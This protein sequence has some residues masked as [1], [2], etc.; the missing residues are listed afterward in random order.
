MREGTDFRW[1][2]FDGKLKQRRSWRG[3]FIL[4]LLFLA[5]VFP[6]GLLAENLG[7]GL[8][9]YSPFDGTSAP[10]FA[11][12]SRE[13]RPASNRF[14]GG[15]AGRALSV[16]E[17][18][19]QFLI[20]AAA[21]FQRGKG[22]LAFW[23][24]LG[25]NPADR[26]GGSSQLYEDENFALSYDGTRGRFFFMTGKTVPQE[27]YKWDYD[28]ST[29]AV[30]DWKAGEWHHLA[31]TWDADSGQKA[32][33]L[34]GKPESSGKTEYLRVD[35]QRDNPYARLGGSAKP[36]AY[37]ELLVW[38]RVLDRKEIARLYAEPR[39]VA[40]EIKA[41][42]QNRPLPETAAPLRW[43]IVP[44]PDPVR[45]VS[46]PGE[47]ME[48]H[49][50]VTNGS[51]VPF[52]QN[53]RFRLYDFWEKCVATKEIPLELGPGERKM[54]AVDFAPEEKGVFKIGVEYENAPE[55]DIFSFAVWP[56]PEA[57]RD[58]DS[59][60]GG[61][62]ASFNEAI[63][64][65]AAR[66]GETWNRNHNM[67]QTTWWPRLQPEPDQ[68]TSMEEAMLDYQKKYGI[69][70]LGQFFGTPHWALAS[71]EKRKPQ[72]AGT[73]YPNSYPYPDPPKLSAFREYVTH[74]VSK[75]KDYIKFWETWNE[76]DVSLFWRGTPQQFA[77][78]AKVAYEAAKK[79]DPECTVMVGGFTYP[80]W[81]WHEETAKAGTLKHADA[82]SIHYGCPML[83]PEENDAQLKAVLKH[84]QA[85]AVQ[86]G[87]GREMP[88]WS[89]EGG[90]ENTTWLRGLDYEFLPPEKER[91]PMNWRMAAIRIVQGS[92]IQQLNGIVKHFY[93]FQNPIPPT[94]PTAYYNTS[95]FE[96]NFSPKPLWIAR[97][98][99]A[100]QV[101]GL[102][103]R[104]LIKRPEGRL[105]ANLY[106]KSG[107]DEV[108]AVCWTG[109]NGKVELPAPEEAPPTIL[110]IV[111][112]EVRPSAKLTITEEPVYVRFHTSFEKVRKYFE[113]AGVTVLK[114]PSAPARSN[115]G[116]PQVP[117]LPDYVAVKEVPDR[118]FFVD[119]RPF[120]NMG[121]A[122]ETPADGRGGWADQGPL[123]DARE[124]PTG[125][126]TFYGV[127]VDIVDPGSNA[128]KSVI[129]LRGSAATPKQPVRVENIP[130]GN[131]NEKI[132]ALYFL[133]AAAWVTTPGAIGKYIIHYKSGKTV[134]VPIEAGKN[135]SDWWVGYKEDQEARP[136]P[137]LSK[138]NETA[139][140]AWRYLRLWEWQNPDPGDPIVSFDMVSNETSAT[141]I[142]VGVTAL[143]IP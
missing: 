7:E 115:D 142:L 71:G 15:Q 143:K 114:E 88:V 133:H 138:E 82:I 83:E 125:R 52:R 98:N 90:T 13:T 25:W 87:P 122:D 42:A 28:V 24:K 85:L 78:I 23:I 135:V 41:E 101:D 50:P 14:T 8:L 118:E 19:D 6:K 55:R 16:P 70:V 59:F 139:R 94:S 86:Y 26:T 18:G 97:L 76:P 109:D 63:V 123:N 141:P 129:V 12:G 77:E 29:P 3:S 65:M 22:T 80:A 44:D 134:E 106:E 32:L 81:R 108:V 69:K 103:Y 37:D 132:R 127:P 30:K 137:F 121:L 64:K 99:L 126:K 57:N 124:L 31:V 34:D 79:A 119:L 11:T 45:L 33:Y 128:G 46:A 40:E 10:A 5:V 100:G 51:S 74:A 67:L 66:L 43:E 17:S 20:P 75:Y 116:D 131:G 117:T 140:P 4:L 136:V 54:V 36:V 73:Q 61:H 49:I 91:E 112:N 21:N 60:F 56:V 96:V 39:A 72:P 113:T 2:I 111:G 62:F 35:A 38:N 104:E 1:P 48:A 120:A 92:V 105:W 53:V 107:R 93:Y 9:W 89:T 102:K 130:V 84:F 68:W 110:N 95:L 58:S 27:G 47:K